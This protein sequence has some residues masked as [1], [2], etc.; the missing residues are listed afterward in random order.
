MTLRSLGAREV[1]STV[2]THII[3][4]KLTY[5]QFI[6]SNSSHVLIEFLMAILCIMFIQTNCFIVTDNQSVWDGWKLNN[7]C[8]SRFVDQSAVFK[9]SS[10]HE[11]R[12][13]L[14]WTRIFSPLLRGWKVLNLFSYLPTILVIPIYYRNKLL[15]F[16]PLTFSFKIWTKNG[17]K[18]HYKNWPN[19]RTVIKPQSI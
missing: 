14:R 2:C 10:D 12:I 6:Q 1:V 13:N 18:K 7:I 16:L 9:S 15:L 17:K 11:L 19:L 4:S 3:Y 8:I 5:W